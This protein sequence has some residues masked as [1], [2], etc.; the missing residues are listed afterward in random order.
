MLW[1]Q[2][3]LVSAGGAENFFSDKEVPDLTYE[4]YGQD[5]VIF[6]LKHE[7]KVDDPP[8]AIVP[9]N[10]WIYS[11]KELPVCIVDLSYST[12]WVEAN[13]ELQHC[14]KVISEKGC[15]YL[16]HVKFSISIGF[17]KNEQHLQCIGLKEN[18]MEI[19]SSRNWLRVHQYQKD[20]T[21]AYGKPYFVRNGTGWTHISYLYRDFGLHVSFIKNM[22]MQVHNVEFSQSGKKSW[23][24]YTVIKD[25]RF[26]GEWDLLF[27]M[28]QTGTKEVEGLAY[29]H[30]KKCPSF[31]DCDTVWM[32][33]W[34]KEPSREQHSDQYIMYRTKDGDIDCICGGVPRDQVIDIM[35]DYQVQTV[36]ETEPW[37]MSVIHVVVGLLKDLWQWIIL[38]L[39]GLFDWGAN[40]VFGSEWQ[41]KVVYSLITYYVVSQISNSTLAGLAIV[42]FQYYRYRFLE[43]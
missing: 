21:T 7:I 43:N 32:G 34:Y 31:L 41:G 42:G 18:I 16:K 38:K 25:K 30:P 36:D 1:S 19:P 35:G 20:I 37:Y 39:T 24:D 28:T 6:W 11:G 23:L 5:E 33:V 2:A 27:A 3:H 14:M 8:P 26:E 9:T 10:D 22:G 17:L 4:K 12:W 40:A 15:F 29:R 13:N